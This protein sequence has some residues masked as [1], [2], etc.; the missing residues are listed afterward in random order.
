MQCSGLTSKHTNSF[1][2]VFNVWRQFIY[3]FSFFVFA[4][5]ILL[6]LPRLLDKCFAIL[7]LNK[8]IAWWWHIL[9]VY[10]YFTYFKLRF[11]YLLRFNFCCFLFCFFISFWKK[12]LK[13]QKQV[14]PE[15]RSWQQFSYANHQ[16]PNCLLGTILLL[17]YVSRDLL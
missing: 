3:L 1:V 4:R 15:C 13:N 10:C 17:F 12:I 16:F 14:Q 5:Q 7:N 9:L 8:N 11:R 2:I 6:F